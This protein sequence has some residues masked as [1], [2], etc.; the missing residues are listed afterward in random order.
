MGVRKI[1]HF[2]RHSP[3]RENRFTAKWP[4]VLF[5]LMQSELP[6]EETVQR[7]SV[8]LM[9]THEEDELRRLSRIL[10]FSLRLSCSGARA[11]SLR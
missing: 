6:G 11:F 2:C 4:H 3:N 7:L 10:T 1:S 5:A 9:H 8:K